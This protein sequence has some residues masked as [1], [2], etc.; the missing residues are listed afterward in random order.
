MSYEDNKTI[1]FDSDINKD[2]KDKA[3]ELQSAVKKFEARLSGG[4]WSPDGKKFIRGAPP[5]MSK[6]E[7]QKAVALFQ[8]FADD[9]QLIA[10]KD[11]YTFSKNKWRV[12]TELNE[13]AV[14]DPS[15]ISKNYKSALLMIMTTQLLILI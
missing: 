13:R 9:I 4:V 6:N 15:T 10:D 11:K 5:L 12:C 7:I 8:S 14:S 1:S 3:T 2:I